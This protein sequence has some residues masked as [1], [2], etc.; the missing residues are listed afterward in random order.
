MGTRKVMKGDPRACHLVISDRNPFLTIAEGGTL[1]Q[2]KTFEGKGFQGNPGQKKAIVDFT[3]G[4]R[5]RLQKKLATI[6]EYETNLPDFITLTYPSEYSE[7]WHQ[8]KR[9]LHAFN[10]ALVRRWPGVWGVWRLEFQERGAP[11]FHF[12]LWDG[13]RVEGLQVWSMTKLKSM[14]IADRSSPHNTEIF[15]WMSQ[16]WFR[17]VGSGDRKHLAAGTRCEP[18][19]TWNGVRFYASKY[20]AKLPDGNFVPVGYAGTG[21]FWGVIGKD[22]WKCTFF[23]KDLPE[24]VF[25]RLRRVIRK[26]LQAKMKRLGKT[27]WKNWRT[28]TSPKGLS[29]FIDSV[30]SLRLL[31]WS[32]ECLGGC[33]F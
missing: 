17:I 7:D 13:P 22:R 16:T 11:H 4:S 23:E 1:F 6:N 32:W 5:S 26:L 10:K 2:I 24:P 33:P 8:W 28:R 18:I 27:R 21:R 25:Y 30:T 15:E 3:S 14:V 29:A 19:Q 9:D 31:A 12:L 20:L